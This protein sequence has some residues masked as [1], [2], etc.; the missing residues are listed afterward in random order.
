MQK[1]WFY[2][3]VNVIFLKKS[4]NIDNG[5]INILGKTEVDQ[6]ALE[7]LRERKRLKN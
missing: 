7:G 4:K 1:F 2:F 5:I 6:V 3:A